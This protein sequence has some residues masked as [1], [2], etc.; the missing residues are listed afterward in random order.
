MSIDA[1]YTIK[2]KDDGYQVPVS[3]NLTK[4]TA[5]NDPPNL[6]FLIDT[7]KSIK[8]MIG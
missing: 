5:E 3:I 2:Y 8:P 6:F 1:G 4:G 7:T